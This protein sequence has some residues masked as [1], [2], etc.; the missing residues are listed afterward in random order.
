MKATGI[1]RRIDDLGRVAIPKE[2]RRI[3]RLKEGDPLE[4]YTEN[5]E[6]IVLQK[7][8]G[9]DRISEEIRQIG[10]SLHEFLKMPVIIG[11]SDGMIYVSNTKCLLDQKSYLE[12]IDEQKEQATIGYITF[13]TKF[14][15]LDHDIPTLSFVILISG[16]AESH[17]DAIM[18]AEKLINDLVFE[19]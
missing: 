12:F 7:Y 5:D 3:M 13:D 1:I 10:K 8:R 18:Y 6:K 17:K 2:I 4:I 11:D 15:I 16:D 14:E 9:V 19:N